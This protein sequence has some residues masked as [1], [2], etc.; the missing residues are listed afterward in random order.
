MQLPSGHI[1]AP[2]AVPAWAPWLAAAVMYA[3]ALALAVSRRGRWVL[4]TA[5][6][7]GLGGTVAAL[8]LTPTVPVSPGYAITLAVPSGRPLTSPVAVTVCGRRADGSA[9]AVPGGGDLLTVLLDGR[10]VLETQRSSLGV[11]AGAGD[12]ELRVELLAP[13]HLQ[14]RP[15]LDA[16][17]RVLVQGT[18]PLAPTP[19]CPRS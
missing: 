4:V 6:V 2:S 15:P 12:H 19:P 3:S 10:Q 1:V 9:V 14:F 7:L 8:L 18:G 11:E 17:L 5:G 16:R 13:G